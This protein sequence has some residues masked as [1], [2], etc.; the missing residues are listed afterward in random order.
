[1]NSDNPRSDRPIHDPE[2][3]NPEQGWQGNSSQQ[4]N[5]RVWLTN[6]RVYAIRNN[7]GCLALAITFALFI[8]CASYC[9]F[10]GGIA[11]LFFYCVIALIGS[12]VAA[13]KLLSGL[14]FNVWQW[15]VCNWAISSLLVFWFSGA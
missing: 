1:M 4:Q 9:G 14:F 3:L 6:S 15:R 7:D 10:L 13:K 5:A 12:L 8:I 11:F 2:I